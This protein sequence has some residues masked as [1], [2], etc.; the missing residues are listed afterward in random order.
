MVLKAV[1]MSVIVRESRGNGGQWVTPSATFLTKG[2][3]Q[4]LSPGAAT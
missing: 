1:K 3:R 2:S 4:V